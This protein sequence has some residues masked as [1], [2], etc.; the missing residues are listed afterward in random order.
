MKILGCICGLILSLY[1]MAE[2]VL[3][4]A[5][6][7]PVYIRDDVYED[8]LK[9][10]NGRPVLSIVDFRG[11]TMRRDVADMVLVQQA[12]ALGGFTKNFYY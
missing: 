2:P 10:L 12:L 5:E 3:P 1:C 8:Y 4:K 6:V 9:F 11:A 7:I